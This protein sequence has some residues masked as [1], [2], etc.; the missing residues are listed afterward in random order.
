MNERNVEAA[1][2]LARYLA[3]YN[4]HWSQAD[5]LEALVMLLEGA[6]VEE[7]RAALPDS[8]LRRDPPPDFSKAP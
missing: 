8:S 3:K 5:D 2:W 4:A 7:V 1:L 6:P